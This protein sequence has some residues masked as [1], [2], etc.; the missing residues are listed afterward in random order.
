[1]QYEIIGWTDYEDENF[2]SIISDDFPYALCRLRTTVIEEI[3]RKGY[4]FCG[5][6]HHMGDSGVPVFNSEEAYRVSEREWGSIMAQAWHEDNRNGFAYAHYLYDCENPF[7]PERFVNF[8][9]IA[10]KSLL[11]FSPLS[12]EVQYM[13]IS[14]QYLGDYAENN[15]ITIE[16]ELF[17]AT[18]GFVVNM[19]LD[20]IPFNQI[21]NGEKSIEL[22][23]Y[24]EKRKTIQCGDTIQFFRKNHEE[25][26]FCA[27]VT[28]VH[29][30][31]S[32]LDLFK[33]NLFS[34]CGFYNM[35]ENEALAKM[36]KYY[37]IE[38]EEKFG[39]VGLEL[40]I[41]KR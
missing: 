41:V 20:D 39:V 19:F 18:F 21:L 29:R 1:M 11:E 38:Q 28:N 17:D 32:F 23:L 13:A 22:R 33:T 8:S 4:R 3:R 7:E 9:K 25:D 16:P 30:F 24:D 31:N 35:S 15:D 36:R 2:P 34:E 37:T 40:K 14:K 6:F 27:R 12:N 5:T 10:D 26:H